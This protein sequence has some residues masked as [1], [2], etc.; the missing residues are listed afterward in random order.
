[1]GS[2]KLRKVFRQSNVAAVKLRQNVISVWRTR[3]LR[4]GKSERKLFILSL[5]FPS[6]SRRCAPIHAAKLR[7]ARNDRAVCWFNRQSNLLPA[8][9]FRRD[10]ARLAGVADDKMRMTLPPEKKLIRAD[11]SAA[12]IPSGSTPHNPEIKYRSREKVFWFVFPT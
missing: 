10:A 7:P 4:S 9:I 2:R 5:L 8:N 6:G 1:M 3:Q 12:L 11:I